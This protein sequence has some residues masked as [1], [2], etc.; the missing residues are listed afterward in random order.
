[1]IIRQYIPAFINKNTGADILI[2][3]ISDELI[4]AAFKR[5]YKLQVL[6]V[7]SRLGR[8]IENPAGMDIA[9]ISQTEG[10]ILLTASF[11]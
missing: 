9:E 1:M 4:N 2:P 7:S 5:R 6:Y 10:R 8:G 11:K 3:C